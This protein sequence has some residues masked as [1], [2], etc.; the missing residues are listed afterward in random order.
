MKLYFICSDF[1]NYDKSIKKELERIG[2]DVELIT[3][4]SMG[5]LILYFQGIIKKKFENL[6]GD[7]IV[8]IIKGE[9]LSKTALNNI[10]NKTKRV[11]IYQWDALKNNCNSKCLLKYSEFIT[12]FDPVDTCK[13]KLRYKALFHQMESFNQHSDRE[14]NVGASFIGTV[15]EDRLKQLI[16]IETYLKKEGV[17]FFFY[18]YYPSKLIFFLRKI[19]DTRLWGVNT[20]D[21][22]FKPLEYSKYKEIIANSIS[23]IDFPRKAQSGYTM[24]TIESLASNTKVITTAEYLEDKFVGINPDKLALAKMAIHRG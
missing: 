18:K 6:D 8:F 11:C 7:N 22:F 20:K 16:E 24:R 3:D 4:Y 13:Y 14:K 23:V 2:Y 1:F 21:V 17:S 15:H 19:I 5:N 10:F 9:T 12:S